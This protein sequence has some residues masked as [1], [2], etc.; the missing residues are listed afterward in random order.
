MEMLPPPQFNIERQI[1]IV[2]IAEGIHPLTRIQKGVFSER[3]DFLEPWTPPSPIPP[4]HTPCLVTAARND[5]GENIL[6]PSPSTI[7]WQ[8]KRVD[9][10]IEE[11]DLND[12]RIRRYTSAPPS[13][14]VNSDTQMY[15]TEEEQEKLNAMYDTLDTLE[16][17]R[18]E[19]YPTDIHCGST[20]CDGRCPICVG[21]NG[22]GYEGGVD[23]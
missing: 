6:E 22:S 13:S 4:I 7:V 5:T 11:S 14:P 23:V 19:E 18:N 15:L 9:V 2:E 8:T 17:Q 1:A 3:P 20:H 21:Y 12:R 16:A 10:D